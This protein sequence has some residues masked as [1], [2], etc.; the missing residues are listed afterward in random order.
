MDQPHA[1]LITQNRGVV[2]THFRRRLS[3]RFCL[4]LLRAAPPAPKFNDVTLDIVNAPLAP[5][6]F[7]RS[8]VSANGQFPGPLIRAT[9]G[10]T[11][12]VKTNNKLTDPTMR[13]STTLDFDGIFF[14]TPNAFNEGT[15][16]VTTC[17]IG[18]GASYTYVLPL[19]QQTGTYWYHSQLSMQYADG[20]RGPLIIYDPEDPQAHLY[21]VDDE[22]TIWF[23][24]DWWH[25]ATLSLLDSYNFNQ[26][27]PVSDSGLFNGRGRY[28]G[29]PETDDFTI[30]VDNHT[31]SVIG[32]DGVPV[33]PH[34]VS[35]IDALAGQRYDVVLTADQPIG[36]YWINTIL[37]GGAPRHNLNLNVTFG[38]GVLHYDGA[39]DAE[40]T[41]P[42]TLGPSQATLPEFSSTNGSSLCPLFPVAPP[43][44]D[45]ELTFLTSMTPNAS[46]P[47]GF[48]SK[49]NINNISYVSPLVPTLVKILDG[50]GDDASD[51]NKTEDTFILPA[52]K[53]IQVTF[54][55]STEDELHPFH[56][57]GNN[58][59]VIKSN[60]S[61]TINEVNPIRRDVSG[62]GAG[63]TILRFTTDRP[64]PWFFHCHIFWHMNAGLA[65]VLATG[66]NETR[67]AVHPT[68]DWDDLCDAYNALPAELQ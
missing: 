29:G 56:L 44:A 62:A 65:A 63:G 30:S 7:T 9:K 59:W 33:N 6:G 66:V 51:Y 36:N 21:D 68:G 32:V 50:D 18:P 2:G 61:D 16:F 12:R 5:D 10:D 13:R 55:P 34:T 25:N 47:S 45:I 26:I 20:L 54:P 43:P 1:P 35:V 52:N 41:G 3:P 39:P 24:S 53:V 19:G 28:N 23:I 40:P 48:D 38:R 14:D 37:G 64:G 67:H 42:M 46:S 11:L 15:P 60:G 57:H 31:L 58:F 27:I 49:W 17:P 8:T 22:S 4:S